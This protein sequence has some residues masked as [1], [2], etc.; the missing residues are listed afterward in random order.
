MR[1]ENIV[2]SVRAQPNRIEQNRTEERREKKR[3]AEK[4]GKLR[5][6]L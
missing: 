6:K 3:R 5:T 1:S 2:G 4:K